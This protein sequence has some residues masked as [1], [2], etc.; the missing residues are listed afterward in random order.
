MCLLFTLLYLI[1]SIIGLVQV[2][3]SENLEANG[4]EIIDEEI[5]QNELKQ[6]EHDLKLYFNKNKPWLNPQLNIWDVAK[7]I[8]TNRSYISKAINDQ[9]GC[10]FNQFVNNYRI[11]EAKKLLK[12]VPEIPIAEISELSGFGSVNSF[13]RIFKS[14]EKCTP[15]KFKKRF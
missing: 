14:I 8:G 10:N 13:I 4:E 3:V 12:K 15:T 11:K 9:I 2:P 7:Q 5:Y 6:L 1:L